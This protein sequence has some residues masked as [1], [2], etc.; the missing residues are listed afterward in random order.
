MLMRK[1]GKTQ[2]G[3]LLGLAAALSLGLAVYLALSARFLAAVIAAGVLLVDLLVLIFVLKRPLDS[4]HDTA[5]ENAQR[6][7]WLWMGAAEMTFIVVGVVV[8]V[9]TGDWYWVCYGLVGLAASLA[10]GIYRT[11]M[12]SDDGMGLRGFLVRMW[13]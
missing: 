13:R 7:D 9:A 2:F 5:N 1:G 11:R 8:W 4:A 6:N 3:V 12:N 10:T